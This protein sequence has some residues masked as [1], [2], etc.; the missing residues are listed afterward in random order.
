MPSFIKPDSELLRRSVA[1]VPLNEIKTEKIQEAIDRLY[2]AAESERIDAK[3]GFLVGIAAPQIGIDLRIILVDLDIG[4][5][6]LRPG[7]FQVFINPEIIWSSSEIEEEREDC[8]SVNPR[9]FGLVPR[10]LRIK[11]SALDREG[12]RV[13]EELSD[14]TA[15]IFQHEIDHLN[16]I[17]FPDRVKND[18]NLHWVEEQN[19]PNYMENWKHWP[20]KCSRNVW[21]SI[22]NGRA[23]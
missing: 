19:Y 6:N 4:S 8:Y 1:S 7:R 14:Y 11:V 13:V 2:A 12:N 21:L 22:K 3:K 16:G 5:D 9:L 18:E 17:C 15:R 20:I 10:A 23:S